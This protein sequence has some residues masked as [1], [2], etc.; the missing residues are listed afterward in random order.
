MALLLM[1][2]PFCAAWS[3]GLP[4]LIYL[5]EHLL[6]CK[7]EELVG[8]DRRDGLL[9]IAHGIKPSA[10]KPGLAEPSD[11]VILGVGYGA[12]CRKALALRAEFALLADVITAVVRVHCF[13]EMLVRG[14]AAINEAASLDNGGHA[15]ASA[16]GAVAGVLH[17]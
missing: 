2:N 16:V 13:P 17:S 10:V 7:V 1:R 14:Y 15:A 4:A 5:V 12:R 9:E 3:S 6:A 11:G 8:G